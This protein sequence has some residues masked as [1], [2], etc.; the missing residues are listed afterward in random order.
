MKARMSAILWLLGSQFGN[1][2]LGAEVSNNA[3]GHMTWEP[4][5]HLTNMALVLSEHY[6][7]FTLAKYHGEN[8]K[9][10]Q[11]APPAGRLGLDTE[12][13]PYIPNWKIFGYEYGSFERRCYAFIVRW[14]DAKTIP[15]I[16]VQHILPSKSQ[17]RDGEFGFTVYFNLSTGKVSSGLDLPMIVFSPHPPYYLSLPVPLSQ[18]PGRKTVQDEDVTVDIVFPDETNNS[19]KD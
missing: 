7:Q 11:T 17:A 18:Q 1:I 16:A 15:I 4:T 3:G 9:N 5:L 8:K 6:A 12:L 2:C 10:D 14:G 19:D 13:P